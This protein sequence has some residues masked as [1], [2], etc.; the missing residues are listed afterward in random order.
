MLVNPS[1]DA[2]R[3]SIAAMISP[4]HKSEFGQFMTPSRIAAF[5]AAM[6]SNIEGKDIRLL[7]AGAGIGSLTAAFVDRAAK[8]PPRSISSI[9]WELDPL[10]REHLTETLE[11]CGEI[12]TGLSAEIV[13][14]DFILSASDGVRYGT[15]RKFTH[16]ILNPPYKKLKTDSGHRRAL[17][18]V[19]VE[20]SNLYTAFVALS[21]HL[22]ED[23]G[24]LVAI[25]PRSFCNGTY[26]KPFRHMLLSHAAIRRVHVFKLR[27][28]AFKGDDVLQENIIFHVVKGVE[29][30]DIVLSTSSDASF[31]DLT[32]RRLL[33]S[34]IVTAGDDERIIYLPTD[35]E[36]EGFDALMRKYS[37]SLED[38]GIG[39]S[40]GPVVDFRL[41]DHLRQ[42]LEDDCVPL[43]YSLHFVEGY[44]SHPK[45]CKKANAIAKNIKTSR[46]LMP[47]G[48][49]V[50]V[51]RLSSKEERR[52]IVPALF[53]P[54][55]VPCNWVGF[56]NHLNVL[57][58]QGRGM[59]PLLARG[60]AVYL[61]S[62]FADRWFRRFNGHTQVN[63]GDLKAIRYPDRK[64]LSTWGKQVCHRFPAQEEIDA[65]VEG[66]G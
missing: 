58:E 28:H 38:I 52:R 39:V 16:I 18:K 22:L 7:D 45:P 36:S 1:I 20:T 4:E 17:R 33:F 21:L 8:T 57:H 35:D 19:G 56:E 66:R 64:T 54:G 43:I 26:F 27:N 42:D 48:H 5:M 46:W 30:D 61:G 59:Q 60:L 47:A 53:D 55:R 40:T 32:E 13:N 65:M 50:L 23:G 6:F 24:E 10:M 2:R 41:K 44:V 31:S 11:V 25:T 29:Q 37:H 62:T 14:D 51:R 12:F 9:A 49:Y 15:A 3:E 34:Q 63:A